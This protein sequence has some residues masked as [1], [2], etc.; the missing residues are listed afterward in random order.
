MKGRGERLLL[1][2]ECKQRAAIGFLQPPDGGP[3]VYLC[4]VHMPTGV[5][6]SDDVTIVGLMSEDER[7]GGE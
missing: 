4:A 5:E 7:K 2:D 6:L 3:P 1:C